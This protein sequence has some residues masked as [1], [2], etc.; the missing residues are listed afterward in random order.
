[1]TSTATYVSLMEAYET[2]KSK[3]QRKAILARVREL[4]CADSATYIK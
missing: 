2:C 1:M 4:A 3:K